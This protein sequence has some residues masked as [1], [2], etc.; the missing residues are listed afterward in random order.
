[1]NKRFL[2]LKKRINGKIS[3][4]LLD[5]KL[6]LIYLKRSERNKADPIKP[7]IY[8]DLQANSYVRASYVLSQYF[9]LQGYQVFFKPNLKFMLNLAAPYARLIIEDD[10]CRFAREKP[11][12][13]VLSL[14]DAQPTPSGFL[15]ISNDYLTKIASQEPGSYY[16]PLGMHPNMYKKK[17]WDQQV[18]MGDR[19]RAVFFAGSF[20]PFEYKRLAKHKKF[21]MLDRLTI[22]KLVKALPNST[23]PKSYE[24]LLSNRKDGQIDMVDKA[25][26]RVPMEILRDTIAKY[27]FFIACPGVDMP[28]SHNLIEAMSVGTIPIIH[29][30]YA[31]MFTP[32]FEHHKNAIIFD[33]GDFVSKVNAA[34]QIDPEKLQ[35]MSAEVLAYYED[36]FT[37]KAVVNKLLSKK[38]NQIYLSAGRTSVGIMKV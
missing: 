31:R 27:A 14:S 10:I 9:H 29:R 11:A 36:H 6:Y 3:R 38:Y 15:P 33:D 35:A 24:A 25:N 30:E 19:V 12:Q 8:L 20:D 23:F 37:P 16:V 13:T 2:N 32:I 1:M 18:N 7:C 5:V 21:N 26:F 4:K 17:L 34:I 22:E 28:L